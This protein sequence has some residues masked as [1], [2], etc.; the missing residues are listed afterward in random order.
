[1]LHKVSVGGFFFAF[2]GDEN[3]DIRNG[4]VKRHSCL[5]NKIKRSGW[6]SGG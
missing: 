1:M 6:K 2:L 3:K 4:H 5:E